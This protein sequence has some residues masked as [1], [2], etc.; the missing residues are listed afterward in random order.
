MTSEPGAVPV[1]R[2]ISYQSQ[3]GTLAILISPRWG[4]PGAGLAWAVPQALL[5]SPRW[6][7]P[8][9]VL[10][11]AVPQALLI[12]PRWGLTLHWIISDNV[13]RCSE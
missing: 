7:L 1:F 2:L 3:V 10:A 5:I 12:S 11:W 13:Y 8:G 6:G 4:L 9:A